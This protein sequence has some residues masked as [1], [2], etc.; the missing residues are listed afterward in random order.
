MKQYLL[1]LIAEGKLGEAIAEMRKLEL[2]QNRYFNTGVIGL[3][4]RFHRNENAKAR[5]SSADYN[6]EYAQIEH[7]AQD[8]LDREF[9]DETVPNIASTPKTKANSTQKAEKKTEIP[10]SLKILMMTAN[11]TGTAKLNLDKEHSSITQ[12]IEKQADLFQLLLRKAVSSDEFKEFTE[13]LK[14]NLLHFSGHG[15][16]GKKGGIFVQNDDKNGEELISTEGLDALFEYLQAEKVPLQAVLLNACY[17]EEQAKTIA[18]YVPY[19]M[20]TTVG[21]GDKLAIAFSAGFYFKLGETNFNFESAFRSGRAQATMAGA[22]KSYF[23]LYKNGQKL[24]L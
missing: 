2:T 14:P 17:S 4:A 5:T 1:N 19:V 6:M 24:E 8:L 3:S 23:S 20:G 10:S 12:K 13:T 18:Q 15:E 11:P 7:A 16:K 9:K 22:A 21:L